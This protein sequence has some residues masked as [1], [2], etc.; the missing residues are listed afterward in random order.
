MIKMII[1]AIQY[2]RQL[3]A[4]ADELDAWNRK[5]RL[6]KVWGVK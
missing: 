4:Y 3:R 2:R 5:A 6:Y 1:E